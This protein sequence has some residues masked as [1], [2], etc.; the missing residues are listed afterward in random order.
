MGPIL[1]KMHIIPRKAQFTAM[2]VV[3]TTNT[4]PEMIGYLPGRIA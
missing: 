2:S 1:V 4:K 3:K